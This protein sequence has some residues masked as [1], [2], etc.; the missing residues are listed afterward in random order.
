MLAAKFQE[1]QRHADKPQIL[2]VGAALTEEQ[3]MVGNCSIVSCTTDG[4]VRLQHLH[5]E[6]IGKLTKFL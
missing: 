1:F 2:P 3:N 6:F 4:A 5:F